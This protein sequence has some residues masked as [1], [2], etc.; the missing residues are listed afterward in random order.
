MIDH[1]RAN[2]MINPAITMYI[3]DNDMYII[4]HSTTTAS[5]ISRN[6]SICFVVFT[7]WETANS[8]FSS[9]KWLV[10]LS[11]WGRGKRWS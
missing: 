8:W 4:Y 7:D 1:S 10:D 5:Q 6:L 3:Y 2:E 11:N 9:I